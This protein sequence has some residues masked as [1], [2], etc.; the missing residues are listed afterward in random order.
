MHTIECI[1]LQNIAKLDHHYSN[2]LL[3]MGNICIFFGL[4]SHLT[5]S[6]F[7]FQPFTFCCIGS[8]GQKTNTP[9][10]SQIPDPPVSPPSNTSRSSLGGILS[11]PSRSGSQGKTDSLKVISAGTQDSEWGTPTSLEGQL[12]SV[13]IFHDV[14]Q[15]T[16]VKGL[17]LA[18]K[19][20]Q[21]DFFL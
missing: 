6:C 20:R 18:G 16:H 15:A 3:I 13:L 4:V 10:P 14:L 19:C 12:A 9:P 17:Y 11:S 21:L 7:V 5:L 8:A 2:F 1:I